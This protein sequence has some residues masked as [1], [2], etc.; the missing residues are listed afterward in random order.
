MES[1]MLDLTPNLLHLIEDAAY[2]SFWRKPTLR[3]FLRR[4]GVADAILAAVPDSMTKRELLGEIVPK[5]ERLASGHTAL[6]KMARELAAQ[7]S[8]PDLQ[9]W[10]ESKEMTESAKQA[11]AALK[12]A[13]TDADRDHEAE[14]EAQVRR[15]SSRRRGEE[16][17][18]TRDNLEKL[19]SRFEK[20]SMESLGTQEGGYAFETWFFDLVTFFEME[21][22]RPYRTP[23][24]RQIDGSLTL[25]GTTYII[26]L[27]F[28]RGQTDV[29]DTAVFLKKVRDKSDNTMGIMVAVSGFNDGAINDASGGGSP[30]L[31]LDA[32]HLYLV[33]T[34]QMTLGE[35][36]SRV[37]RHSSQ[38]GRAYLPAAQFST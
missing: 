24:K 20:L 36:I 6:E 11:V 32:M 22:K 1:P 33:L 21:H 19:K 23:E 26:E 14:A 31:L 5:L 38:Y 29:V 9:G 3:K 18:A 25:E 4:S 12:A 7:T 16:F 13:I 15:E 27:K 10:E 8:F 35:V 37:R 30:L 28:E 17:I 2:K 34:S